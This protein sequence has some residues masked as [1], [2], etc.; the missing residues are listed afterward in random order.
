MKAKLL[1]DDGTKSWVIV[2]DEG[3]EVMDVLERVA[4]EEGLR[5]SRFTAIGAFSRAVLGYF[6]IEEPPP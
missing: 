5:A 2:L 6:L 3:D 1:A 4:R